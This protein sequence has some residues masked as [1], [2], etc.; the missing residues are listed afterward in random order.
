M[1]LCPTILQRN[2]IFRN[3]FYDD[4]KMVE[5]N[6]EKIGDKEYIISGENINGVVYDENGYG[7][8]RWE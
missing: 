8:F 4:G 1:S 7:I 3:V 6:A 5:V 2:M